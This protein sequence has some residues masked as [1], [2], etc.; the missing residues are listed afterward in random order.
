MR[1]FDARLSKL[2]KQT[3]TTAMRLTVRI[4]K[5]ESGEG[6]SPVTVFVDGVRQGAAMQEA[7]L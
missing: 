2:E 3:S 7:S 4:V 6:W 5:H 1:N